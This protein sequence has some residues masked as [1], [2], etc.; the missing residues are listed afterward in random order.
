MLRFY[1]LLVLFHLCFHAL[2]SLL[3]FLHGGR[4]QR[5][6]LML[7]DDLWD[8]VNRLLVADKVRW[9]LEE[10]L[11]AEESVSVAEWLSANRLD[12]LRWMTEAFELWN[13]WERT[14]H[15][16]ACLF[17]YFRDWMELEE[18]GVN[19]SVGPS[20]IIKTHSIRSLCESTDGWILMK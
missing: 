14:T 3:E 16:F 18:K 2:K 7:I 4:L 11:H 20:L 6:R 1:Y 8:L 5:T 10:T 13:H 17:L 15:L 19:Q 12:F 9:V